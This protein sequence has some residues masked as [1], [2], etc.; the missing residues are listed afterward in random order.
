MFRGDIYVMQDLSD[1]LLIE[2]LWNRNPVQE[3][4][5]IITLWAFNRTIVES[6]LALVALGMFAHYSTFNR[7]IVE[8]KLSK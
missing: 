7:T 8:S 5:H 2:L 4:R 6:K 3:P 1:L